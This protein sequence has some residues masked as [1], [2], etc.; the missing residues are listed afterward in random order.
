MKRTFINEK[1]K[2]IYIEKQQKKMR[3]LKFYEDFS[4]N[5]LVFEAALLLKLDDTIKTKILELLK[6]ETEAEGLFPLPD[7]KLHITLT[8]IKNCKANKDTLKSN[9]PQVPSPEIEYPKIEL[10]RT[11][12]A[13]RAETGK[14]SFV[15]EIANQEELKSFVDKV[16]AAISLEN[17]ETD[18]H[19]HIT[20]AN[21]VE[22]K[23]APGM[24]DPFGSIGDI[25]KEDF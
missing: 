17:P 9:L 3:Y 18:R 23:K 21:N 2:L 14:K 13:E 25:T 1:K 15:V 5:K 22:N 4:E 10:G 24:A 16:Y 19:F 7:D 6:S 8:S 20:I 11:T 12:I